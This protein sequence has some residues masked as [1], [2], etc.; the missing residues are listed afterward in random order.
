MKINNI[1][2]ISATGRKENTTIKNKVNAEEKSVDKFER[3]HIPGEDVNKKAAHVY[4]KPTIQ[5]LKAES[6]RV[7][8]TLRKLVENLLQRQGKTINLANPMDIIEVDDEARIEAQGMIAPDG[9]L[10]AE[11]VSQRIVDFAIAISG[12]DKSK[13]DTLR[14]AIDK[15]FKQAEK[16]LGS[17]PDISRQTYDLITEKLDRW[18]KEE[19]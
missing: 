18:E 6:D 1:N 5:K 8:G 11:A 2:P 12:G 17:L 9:P 4:D 10:G 7:Y 15:G 19:G 16:V 3:S 14:S 13:L